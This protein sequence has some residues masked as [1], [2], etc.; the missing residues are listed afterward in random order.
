MG[1]KRSGHNQSGHDS[2]KNKSFLS[3]SRVR[4]C[5]HARVH[6]H[7]F[8][9]ETNTTV[10]LSQ[11]VAVYVRVIAQLCVHAWPSVSCVLSHL[12]CTHLAV[13][14]PLLAHD[15]PELAS[16]LMPLDSLK[17]ILKTGPFV[18][19]WQASRSDDCQ[20]KRFWI[21]LQ[22]QPK[23]LQTILCD[24]SRHEGNSIPE[25]DSKVSAVSFI[26]HSMQE[27][28]SATFHPKRPIVALIYKLIA[29]SEHTNCVYKLI[30]HAFGGRERKI[31]GSILYHSP[32]NRH[33]TCNEGSYANA[34]ENK[35]RV[36]WSP[37]G[38]YLLVLN[39]IHGGVLHDQ[40]NYDWEISLFH[41]NGQTCQ[42]RRIVTD[43]LPLYC[44]RH[45]SNMFVSCWAGPS[46][47]Y[48]M[49][50]SDPKN[51]DSDHGQYGQQPLFVKVSLKKQ[52]GHV[53]VC[54]QNATSGVPDLQFANRAKGV[55]LLRGSRGS[56]VFAW[57]ESC[58]NE[59]HFE[60]SIVRYRHEGRRVDDDDKDTLGF[61]LNK[62]I[63]LNGEL[64]STDPASLLLLVAQPASMP[65]DKDDWRT[66]DW[67]PIGPSGLDKGRYPFPTFRKISGRLF[68][69]NHDIDYDSFW[70]MKNRTDHLLFLIKISAESPN[71]PVVLN[72]AKKVHTL[73]CDLGAPSNYKT[74]ILN[75]SP[76]SL[77]I[78]VCRYDSSTLVMSKVLPIVYSV[79]KEPVFFWHPTEQ[80][81]LS[82]INL[83]NR[84]FFDAADDDDDDDDDDD[85]TKR[86][87]SKKCLSDAWFVVLKHERLETNM[88]AALF[89]HSKKHELKRICKRKPQSC[90]QCT[91]LE[92]K[93]LIQ[94]WNDPLQSKMS[95]TT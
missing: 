40:N 2:G 63:V 1:S 56:N 33:V 48:L 51:S 81:Y 18:D 76:T 22:R 38:T 42:L 73:F 60:H 49:S 70:P 5:A 8:L 54:V 14:Y 44:N 82:K 87:Q 80:I 86:L 29:T 47:F 46:S 16:R 26:E 34:Y 71:L 24:K 88:E 19:V 92:T 15:F 91:M 89:W 25:T 35:S 50:K 36:T 28:L 77:L 57:S 78:N 61:I 9:I 3:L 7:T 27:V 74:L 52:S 43:E 62:G 39:K 93:T 20:T 32:G 75:Q 65:Y 90:A 37:T 94:E 84:H 53:E 23:L 69:G 11:V 72:V 17:K 21:Q 68:C 58:H 4:T 30:L 95:K 79:Q 6:T 45:V 12:E 59:E 55:W 41:W 13:I 83:Y 67:S 64:D 31:R 10:S 66:L 85:E